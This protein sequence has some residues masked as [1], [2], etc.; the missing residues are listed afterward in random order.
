MSCQRLHHCGI[1][2]LQQGTSFPLPQFPLVSGAAL[3]YYFSTI[4]K[5][6]AAAFS[7]AYVQFVAQAVSAAFLWGYGNEARILAA[8]S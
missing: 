7:P 6:A 2:L 8:G 1:P 3:G 4:F 5:N